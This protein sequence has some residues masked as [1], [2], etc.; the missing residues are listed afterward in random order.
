MP[1]SATS[2]VDKALD[3]IEAVTAAARPPRLTELAEQVGLHRA[4]AY[5]VLAGL[6]E[7]GWV[8]K[9]GET[10]LPGPAV[11]RLARTAASGSASLAGLARPVL[12]DLARETGLM[13]NLQVLEADRSRVVDVV[14]PARLE[15]I[16]DL[17]D[18][19]LPAHRFAGPLALV[20]ALGP[21]EREPY[22]RPAR[23]ETGPG[24]Q[25]AASLGA[26]LERAAVEGFAV[27]RGATQRLVASVGCAVRTEPGGPGVCALTLVG[28]IAEFDDAHLPE[29]ERVLRAAAE[30]LGAELARATAR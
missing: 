20:A 13:V 12:E 22:L 8:T 24:A 27:R 18:E 4:T 19:L 25:S 1:A 9:V 11:L 30:R 26:E 15:M 5:R 7:R 14:R 17:R 10:Y 21:D 29:L 28:P 3:L 6:V 23:A 2:A 16:S